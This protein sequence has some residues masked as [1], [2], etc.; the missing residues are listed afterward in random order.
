M[1]KPLKIGI[2]YLLPELLAHAFCIFISHRHARAISAGAFKP[3]FYG[4]Y[5]FFIR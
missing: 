3:F 4:F 5:G 1:A 2:F